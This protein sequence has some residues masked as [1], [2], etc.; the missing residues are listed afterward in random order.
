M[1]IAPATALRTTARPRAARGEFIVRYAAAYGCTLIAVAAAQLIIPNAWAALLALV[2]LLGLPLSLLLRRSELRLFGWRVPRFLINSTIVILSCCACAYVF[3]ATQP[4]LLA[5]GFYDT[6]MIARSAGDV[7]ALLMDMFLIFAVFRSLAIITDK[8]AVLSAVPSFSIL[9]LLIVV[10][11]GPQVV[12]YFL[13]W[14]VAAAILFSLDH[15]AEMRRRLSGVV[16]S[17]VPGQDM[18]LAARG[19]ATVLGF[20]L[21][22]A[23]AISSYLSSRNPEERG[24]LENWILGMAGRMT[25]LALNLPDISVNSGPERQI[26]YSTGPALP[27]R[28]EL[29]MVGASNDR[30]QVLHPQYWRMFTLSRYN[31]STWS[32]A[33]GSGTAIPLQRLGPERWPRFRPPSQQSP[34]S[35]A[36]FQAMPQRSFENRAENR[37]APDGRSPRR[38]PDEWR[39]RSPQGGNDDGNGSGFRRRRRR[40]Y[41]I[42]ARYPFAAQMARNFGDRRRFVVQVMEPRVPNVGFIPALP[43]ARILHIRAQEPPQSVRV[44][45]DGAIDAGVLQPGQPCVVFS[46]VAP[47]SAYGR[48]TTEDSGPPLLKS[49]KP[50]PLARLSRSERGANLQLPAQLLRPDSRMRRF[51]RQVLRDA[52]ARESDY[53]RAKRLALAVQSGAVYTLRPPQIPEGQDAAEYFLFESRRGYCTYFAGALT[54]ACRVAGIPARVVSGFV[55]PDW[56]ASGQQAGILREAN[57]HAWTEV[58][59]DGWGWAPLDAT[60]ADDRGNNAPDWWDNWTYFF[61]SIADNARRWVGAHRLAAIA[62]AL[63]CAVALLLFA[64]RRGLTDP[65]VARLAIST[66]GRFAL[67]RDQAHR[68][69]IKAYRRAAKRLARKFRRAAAWETPHEYLAAAEAALDLENP[70]P[71]RELTQLYERAQYAPAALAASDGARAYQ[72]LRTL[73]LRARRKP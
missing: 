8:D 61:T 69:V 13:L 27:T 71:L 66:R 15:R 43:V 33:P 45:Q 38:G 53:M 20:S 39:G 59:V 10:H 26:D 62:L 7:I 63:A 25:Q 44:R 49:R 37:G 2:T 40:G 32:Q 9:L 60:P 11:R 23:I 41:D 28:A 34:P 55:N 57:A 29:W 35:G 50:N 21:L 18:K 30:F 68:L 46:E 72:A 42:A 67:G 17:L 52:P 24:L 36:T 58:W 4:E 65:L 47:V 1:R 19:L 3:F 31:G 64:A 22:C 6:I 14:A 73:S 48:H 51:V 54:V 5:R 70:Q 12:A 56:S 16:P